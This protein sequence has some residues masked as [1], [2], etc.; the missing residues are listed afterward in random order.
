M[1]PLKPR[2]CTEFAD[3]PIFIR[4]LQ[5]AM[6]RYKRIIGDTLHAHSR[7][8]QRVETQIAVHVLNRML[9]LGRPE[10]A[11]AA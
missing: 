3:G 5:G 4:P 7:P 6:S 8:A 9:A 10:S 1:V 2:L 11:R